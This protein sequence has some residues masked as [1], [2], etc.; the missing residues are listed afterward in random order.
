MRKQLS[1]LIIACIAIVSSTQAQ[2]IIKPSV[3]TATS[4]AIVIDSISYSK[5]KTAVDAYK[6]VIEND[7]LSTYI[8]SK[9][10]TSPEEIKSLLISLYKKSASPLE[11]A[12]FVGDIPIPMLRDAQHLSTA[13]KM[14]QQ[15]YPWQRS[16]IPSDRFYDDFDLK[17]DFLKQDD[18]EPLFFYY[19]LR[20]DGAQ[21]LHSNIYSARIK[22]YDNEKG[23][24]YTHLRH[25]LEKVVRERTYN[26]HNQLNQLSMGRGH[27]YNSESKV[28]W[29]GEQMALKEQFPLAFSSKGNV[30]FMD[31]DSRWPIKEYFLQ[32]VQRPGLDVMLFH[33]HG[34]KN[35][36]YLNGYKT[37]SDPATSTENIKLYARSKIRSA[38]KK[39]GKEAAIKQYTE[40]LDIPTSWVEN[41]FDSAQIK[42]DSLLDA[43]LDINIHDI[44]NIAPQARFIMFDACY[45][46][47]FYA[48][49]NIAGEYIF[50]RGNTLVTQGNTVNVIQDKYP[51]EF[52]GL[53]S[54]GMRVGNWHR[55]IN[56]LETHLIGDPTFRFAPNIDVSFDIND[57]IHT[58]KQDTSF[59]LSQLKTSQ[60]VDMQALALRM[61]LEN[62]YSDISNLLKRAYTGSESMILRTQAFFLLSKLD[63]TNFEEVLSLAVK[64]SYELIRRFAVEFIAKNGSKHLIPAYL[65]SVCQDDTS[66]R[67]VFKQENFM[68]MLTLSELE[69][70]IKEFERENMLDKNKAARIKKDIERM[71]YSFDKT[72]RTLL[73]NDTTSSTKDKIFEIKR[74]RNHPDHKAIDTLLEIIADNTQDQLVRIN[75][76]EALGWYNY[77]HRREEI[78]E[79]LQQMVP[80]EKS[81]AVRNELL[82]TINRLSSI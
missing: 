56:H 13:F 76:A 81:I 74:F 54:A 28:A 45:N 51:D 50:N 21:K 48:K 16:S 42:K 7:G 59:W 64:D 6:A 2:H 46:G 55:L 70:L 11:G 78:I 53:L 27:G 29:A 25:Y 75:T 18:K 60:L 65:L 71:Q 44:R 61:L 72:M 68:P 77:S 79:K 31:F 52:L 35:M 1:L 10:W 49:E 67:V 41:S 26:K 23:D 39:K 22:P 33:H 69:K 36:Q 43:S 37:G 47:S 9:Q 38:A 17:F 12:V 57:I 14:D 63:D 66:E 5:A 32:E 8:I 80:K 58:K 4:F 62:Q 73:P 19:S 3:K 24:K 82:K 40:Y 34:G 20:H 15:K 30:K